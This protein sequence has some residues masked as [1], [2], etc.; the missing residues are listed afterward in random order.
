MKKKAKILNRKAWL[1]AAGVANRQTARVAAAM[2]RAIN[3]ALAHQLTD[4]AAIVRVGKG[5]TRV[6]LPRAKWAHDLAHAMR[7]HVIALA[8]LGWHRAG[9]AIGAQASPGHHHKIHPSDQPN[10][11]NHH[12]KMDDRSA[13]HGKAEQASPGGVSIPEYDDFVQRT[14]WPRL[15]HWVKTTA[16]GAA[17][18]SSTRLQN[19]FDRAAKFWD[20][21]KKQ[22]MTSAQI[23]KQ[24]LAEGATQD[25]ARA[26]MLARTGSIWAS[27]EGA[28]ERYKADGVAAVQWLT[29]EDDMTCP[30]CVEMDG[31]LAET[32]HNF[33]EAGGLLDAGGSSMKVPDSFSIQHPPLHPN[34]RCALIPIVDESQLA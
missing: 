10:P 15:D 26:E 5:L 30:F 25:K 28:V 11:S 33:L 7:P 8:A 34:C 4:A 1:R 22:G 31:T 13:L 14:D 2:Q 21:D 23:A 29:T 9:A 19:I 3:A 16:D 24:I 27:N 17:E 18:T 32:G 6:D 20:P 12:H